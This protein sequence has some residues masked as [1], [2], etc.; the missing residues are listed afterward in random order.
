MIMTVTQPSSTS[1]PPAGAHLDPRSIAR[2]LGGEVSGQHIL[3]PGPGHSPKDRS[4]SIKVDPT[5]PDG[6]LIHSFANDDW[7][8]CRE[9]IRRTLGMP[10]PE[11]KK[12]NGNGSGGEP[13]KFIAEH[14]YRD[15]GGEPYLRVQ[16][17]LD[18]S[19]R[20]QYPQFHFENG[21]WAKGKPAGA[22]LPYRLPEL[23]AAPLNAPVKFCEGE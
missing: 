11:R 14:V 23:I 19:G 22:K 18:E 4:L 8:V 3:A 21:A 16:K 2:A 5:A 12:A 10:E 1:L 9:H 17:Y 15:E 7:K 13:W 6:I 20:K